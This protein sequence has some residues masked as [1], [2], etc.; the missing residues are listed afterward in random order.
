MLSSNASISTEFEENSLDNTCARTSKKNIVISQR[1]VFNGSVSIVSLPHPRNGRKTCFLLKAGNCDLYE[2]VSCNEDNRSWFIGDTVESNG[3]IFMASKFDPLLLVL[4]FLSAAKK[5]EPLSQILTHEDFPQLSSF[6]SATME[7]GG[8]LKRNLERV[9]DQKGS[10]DLNVWQYNEAKTLQYLSTKVQRVC[11]SLVKDKLWI[12]GGAI[13]GHFVKTMKKDIDPA[14]YRRYSLGILSEY[15]EDDLSIKLRKHMCIPLDIENRP[16]TKKRPPVDEHSSTKKKTK[17][18][19]GDD[20]DIDYSK[21]FKVKA[22]AT[23]KHARQNAK[24]K[25]LAKS[26]EGSTSITSFFR[27][28]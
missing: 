5:L 24:Q 10:A 28:K 2:V 25:A 15:L 13:S 23:L 8:V 19:H 9:A 26:A 7:S 6:V 22:L 14:I 4:P 3:S 17:V 16:P 12:E 20:P 18:D 21:E 27:K 1:S 11:D